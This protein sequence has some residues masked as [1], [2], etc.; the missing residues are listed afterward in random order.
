MENLQEKDVIQKIKQGEIDYYSVIVKTYAG[1]IDNYIKSR[2]F[3]KDDSD[4]L[5]QN[6]FISFYKAIAGFDENKPV[7]PY[8]FEI[9]RNE[10]KMH[11]RTRKTTAP[12]REE[13]AS[14]SGDPVDFDESILN[15]LDGKDKKILLEI[16]EGYSNEEV[17]KKY[18][19]SLN[20]LKSKIRRARLK[21]KKIH[22]KI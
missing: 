9:A 7:L 20:N 14:D 19:I 5:T 17:A 16:S 12:L 10:L 22:E 15:A 11:Y 18:K 8:L 2:L 4:D 6:V 21:I 13:M 1:R 3:D